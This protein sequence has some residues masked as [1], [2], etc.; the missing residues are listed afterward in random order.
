MKT[1]KEKREELNKVIDNLEFAEMNNFEDRLKLINTIKFL[2]KK[3]DEEFIEGILDELE[4]IIVFNG[5][6][7]GVIKDVKK[8]IKQKSGFEE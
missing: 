8:I 1:L 3:Q 5:N 2:I 6:S 4:H 7:Y